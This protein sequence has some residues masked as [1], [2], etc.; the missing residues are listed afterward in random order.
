MEEIFEFNSVTTAHI[1]LCI[2]LKSLYKMINNGEIY[3]NYKILERNL[4]GTRTS[5]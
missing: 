2:N 5:I 4:N 3:N 1:T